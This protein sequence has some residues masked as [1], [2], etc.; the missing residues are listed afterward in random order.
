MIEQWRPMRYKEVTSDTYEVSTMGN[1]RNAKT[2]RILKPQSTGYLHVRIRHDGKLQNIRIHRAVAETF[3]I[4]AEG[5]DYVNHIDG[6][7][8]NNKANNLE[9][10]TQQHNVR[11]SLLARGKLINVEA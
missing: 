6:D 8:T 5:Y 7:K 1:I 4:R 9:W 11:S 2:N 3:L 10:C